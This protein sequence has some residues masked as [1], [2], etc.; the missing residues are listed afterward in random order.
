MMVTLE[1]SYYPLTEDFSTPI[2]HLLELLQRTKFTVEIGTMSTL[3]TGEYDELMPHLTKVMGELMAQY[4]SVF[5][6]KL[7][8]ACRV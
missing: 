4:P 6:I 5:N 2:N 8:N 1:I 7:S 3:I